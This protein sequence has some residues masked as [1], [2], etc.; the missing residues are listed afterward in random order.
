MIILTYH[1]FSREK[2]TRITCSAEEL[3]SQLSYLTRF[4]H[5]VPLLEGLEAI[6]RGR[7]EAKR[8]VAITIDDCDQSL[9]QIAWPIFSRFKVPIF[10][11]LIT[12]YIGRRIDIGTEVEVLGSDELKELAISGLVTFGSHTANH[13]R[14]DEVTPAQLAIELESSKKAIE[15]IQG[16]CS[17]FC[18]PY[19]DVA[20]VTPESERLLAQ[21]GYK[22]AL[23][24]CGGVVTRSTDRYRVGRAT[25]VASIPM[26]CF[27]F[28]CSGWIS[29]YVALSKYV[30]GQAYYNLHSPAGRFCD[31]RVKPE[32]LEEALRARDSSGEILPTILGEPVPG[33]SRD[34]VSVVIPCY[35]NGNCV[36]RAI[37]SALNQTYPPMEVIVVNDGSSD[38]SEDV[39]TALSSRIVYLRQNNFGPATARNLGVQHARGNLV[40][41]L[42]ADDY[43]CPG[44][45]AQCCEFLAEHPEAVAVST[46]LRFNLPNGRTVTGPRLIRSGVSGNGFVISKFFEFWAEQ[47][48]IRTGSCVFRRNV[49]F[50]VGLMNSNLRLAEDLELWALLATRGKWGFIPEVL[51]VGDSDVVAAR[52]GWLKKYRPRWKHCP[53]MAEWTRRIIPRLSHDDQAG[54]RIM[55]GTVALSFAMNY[56]LTGHFRKAHKIVKEYS[57][58]G[59]CG[60]SGKLLR[61]GAAVGYPSFLLAAMIIIA[62]EYQKGIS[63]SLFKRHGG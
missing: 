12:G 29:R 47:N 57:S 63:L 48:H 44:F 42:D 62:R 43:W 9:F 14:C 39:I 59:K 7:K 41:F 54:F 55:C 38:N 37:Q 15:A 24:T 32:P 35:N 4:C 11:N 26:R 10:C 34:G 19:G 49:Y 33:S 23:T 50:E 25:I 30:K 60:L 27:P 36:A 16:H 31:S 1:F 22:Y 56:L 51:W 8:T 58:S 45:L 17:V 6:E 18:Y 52:D 20:V 40:T 13:C 28:Y 61:L 3:T 21:T 5:V 2:S 53:S 46:G